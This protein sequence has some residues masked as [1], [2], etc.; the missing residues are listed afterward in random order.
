MKSKFENRNAKSERTTPAPARFRTDISCGE[1]T[2]YKFR[3]VPLDPHHEPAPRRL[4]AMNPGARRPRGAD[5][6]RESRDASTRPAGYS[7]GPPI[8]TG[9]EIWRLDRYPTVCFE[10]VTDSSTKRIWRLGLGRRWPGCLKP[11][12]LPAARVILTS[13]FLLHLAKLYLRCVSR[14][15]FA[16]PRKE[17]WSTNRAGINLYSSTELVRGL[18]RPPC[19]RLRRAVSHA[20][21]GR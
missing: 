18:D 1:N 14:A 10:R 8:S 15:A 5:S 16:A 9:P 19:A 12:A 17:Y 7:I 4:R 6:G 11:I 3:A 2:T 20:T 21:K 13:S